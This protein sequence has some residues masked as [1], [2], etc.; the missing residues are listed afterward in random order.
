MKPPSRKDA[1]RSGAILIIVM[2]ILVT[3]SL[4]VIAL[5]ELGRHSD[6]EAEQQLLTTQARWVSEAGFE[7]LK[8]VICTANDD[9]KY[10]RENTIHS[11]TGFNEVSQIPDFSETDFGGGRFT[12][13]ACRDD[14][15]GTKTNIF[16]ITSE[17]TVSNATGTAAI[18]HTVRAR[19][20]GF[21]LIE[22]ALMALGGDSYIKQSLSIGIDGDIYIEGSGDINISVNGEVRDADDAYSVSYGGTTH[23]VPALELDRLDQTLYNSLLAT[24]SSDNPADAYQGSQ[25]Y[26]NPINLDA[27]TDNTLYVNGDI[28]LDAN[29]TGSG[30]IV[31]DGSV[32][33]TNSWITFTNENIRIVAAGDINLDGNNTTFQNNTELFTQNDI[34]I[35]GNLNWP[36]HGMTVMAMNDII[37]KANVVGFSGIIYAEGTVELVNG[38]QDIS[39]S[40]VAWNGFDIRSNASIYYDPLVFAEELPDS[41]AAFLKN[42]GPVGGQLWEEAPF[43]D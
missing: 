20:T 6:Y 18:T 34:L 17:G 31:A 16:Y 39:G 1:S 28:T 19:L 5:L 32:I 27:E 42:W 15:F 26:T 25:T 40:I 24:A 22:A 3:F 2:V 33:I 7:K 37:V 30:T 4:M 29:I 23:S 12:V 9:C 8:A 41:I 35:G 36:D 38:V 14:I 21:P 10:F 11:G 43:P 13:R